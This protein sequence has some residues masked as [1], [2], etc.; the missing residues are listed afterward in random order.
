MTGRYLHQTVLSTAHLNNLSR[1]IQHSLGRNSPSDARRIQQFFQHLTQ[2]LTE[3]L[4]PWC[5]HRIKDSP[6]VDDAKV[7]A[8]HLA[9]RMARATIERLWRRSEY[10]R[11]FYTRNFR[12]AELF[13]SFNLPDSF[14]YAYLPPE[15][16]LQELARLKGNMLQDYFQKTCITEVT[17]YCDKDHGTNNSRRNQ[18]TLAYLGDG[19]TVWVPGPIHGSSATADGLKL[20]CEWDVRHFP[21]GAQRIQK[22]DPFG[23]DHPF[24]GLRHLTNCR[25]HLNVVVA[26]QKS[27][28][29]HIRIPR[30]P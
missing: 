17:F 4:K 6:S 30:L 1:L 18:R 12:I 2:V 13:R 21:D 16:H 5:F 27:L 24:K 10:A 19:G 11:D 22:S 15:N 3:R 25:D 26:N 23:I 14:L 7:R 8:G 29:G 20:I 9:H 28:E